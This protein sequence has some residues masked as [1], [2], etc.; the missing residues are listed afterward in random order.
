M[1]EKEGRLFFF[2]N[3]WTSKNEVSFRSVLEWICSKNLLEPFFFQL[4]EIN[5]LQMTYQFK[6]NR[7]DSD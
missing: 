7:E 3:I 2:F 6:P 1:K 5:A 4:L